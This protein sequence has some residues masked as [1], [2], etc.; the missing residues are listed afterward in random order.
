MFWK[1]IDSEEYKQLLHKLTA[2]VGDVDL[3]KIQIA[4]LEANVRLANNKLIRKLGKLPKE[5]E[6]TE[7][8]DIYSGMLLPER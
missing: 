3:L 7:T 2:V 6:E 4:N 1:K 5:E 8:K